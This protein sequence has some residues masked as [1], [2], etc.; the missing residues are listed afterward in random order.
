MCYIVT[1][2]RL[3]IRNWQYLIVNRKGGKSDGRVEE[4][5]R[6]ACHP[7]AQIH[8][9]GTRSRYLAASSLP[10]NKLA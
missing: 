8:D 1:I 2:C 3:W 7:V 4:A 6:N 10:G 5:E 9:N